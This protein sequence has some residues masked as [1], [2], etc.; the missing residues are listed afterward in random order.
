MDRSGKLPRIDAINVTPFID[1]LLVLLVIFLAA[2]PLTE[3]ALDT[4]LPS[5]A[6]NAP[7]PDTSIVVEYDADRQ[8][9]INH[10]VVALSDLEARLRDVYTGRVDKTLYVMA[11]GRLPYRAVI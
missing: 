11:D 4:N 6:A 10:Q 2:L 1:I 3:Q 8:L 9:S 5:A 7:A